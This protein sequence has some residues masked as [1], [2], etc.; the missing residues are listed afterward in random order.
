MLINADF[1]FYWV[2]LR[3]AE[4][5]LVGVQLQQGPGAPGVSFLNTAHRVPEYARAACLEMASRD[6]QF[7]GPTNTENR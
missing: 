2:R 6:F 3:V 5:E 7:I 1:T 4:A